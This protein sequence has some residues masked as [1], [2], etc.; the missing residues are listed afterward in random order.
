MTDKGIQEAEHYANAVASVM[1]EIWEAIQKKAKPELVYHALCNI[2]MIAMLP[3]RKI[4]SD[5]KTEEVLQ[6]LST[7]AQK[8]LIKFNEEGFDLIGEVDKILVEH[9]LAPPIEERAKQ[10][11]ERFINHI[12]EN[13]EGG[14]PQ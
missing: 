4:I 11:E 10:M 3:V 7:I 9:K 5:G 13:F 14:T 12:L 6:E 1:P 8:V 2:H